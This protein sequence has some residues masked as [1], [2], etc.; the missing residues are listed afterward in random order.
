MERYDVDANGKTLYE[1]VAHSQPTPVALTVTA[2]SKAAAA[3]FSVALHG[4]DTGMLVRIAGATG[5]WAGLNGDHA[6]TS[7]GAGTFTVAVSSVAYAGDFN[8]TVHC[9]APRTKDAVWKISKYEYDGNSSLAAIKVPQGKT[10][11]AFKWDDRAT[12]AYQ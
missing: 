1:G 10:T 4:M 11:A 5:D 3:E 8:G 12:L 6:I 9:L 7:T 2:V